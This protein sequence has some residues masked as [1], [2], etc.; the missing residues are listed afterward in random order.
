MKI[1]NDNLNVFGLFNRS[2]RKSLYNLECIKSSSSK[3]LSAQYLHVL[4][5]NGVIGLVYLPLSISRGHEPLRQFYS[6]LLFFL[7]YTFSAL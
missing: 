5:S 6:I 7:Q 3:Q 2:K 1:F 4:K